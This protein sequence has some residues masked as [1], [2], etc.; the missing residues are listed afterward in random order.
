MPGA[1]VVRETLRGPVPAA[2][3]GVGFFMRPVAMYRVQKPDGSLT[4]MV[5]LTRAKDAGLAI[6]TAHLNSRHGERAQGDSPVRSA[7][8]FDAIHPLSIPD[9]NQQAPA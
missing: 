3:F 5:N 4:D 8:T 7:A 9:A 2:T 1:V 6:A